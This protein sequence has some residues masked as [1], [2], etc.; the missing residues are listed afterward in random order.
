MK[1]LQPGT[2]LKNGK[3]TINKILGQGSFGI[4]YLAATKIPMQGD[5]GKMDVDVKVAIKEFFMA[6]LNSRSGDGTSLEK[7]DSSIVKKY[8][9]KFYT[10]AENLAKLNHPNIVKVLEV[11]NENNTSY[12]VMEY[13]EGETLDDYIKR[14]GKIAIAGDGQVTMGENTIF[15]NSAKKV[16]RI[17]GGKVWTV[18]RNIVPLQH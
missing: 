18:R 7:T 13:I 5:F 1:A 14:N 10:E 15:K 3:Y 16:R 2:T 9:K 6:D 12:Y 17:F 4:T 11:F 8:A